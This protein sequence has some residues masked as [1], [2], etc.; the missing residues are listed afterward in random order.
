MKRRL[1]LF[2]AL[3]LSLGLLLPAGE[4]FAE[5][6]DEKI[7]VMKDL[8]I[9]NGYPD[10]SLGLKKPLSVRKPRLFWCGWERS[11]T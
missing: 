8:G 6:R 10:G 5:S 1:K 4:A 9:V 7:A 3:L 11:S 2:T